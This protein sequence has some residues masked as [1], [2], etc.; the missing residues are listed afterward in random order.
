VNL[1]QIGRA[2]GLS[3]APVSC[4]AQPEGD[5]PP[6]RRVISIKRYGFVHQAIMN[7]IAAGNTGVATVLALRFRDAGAYAL[8]MLCV[9]VAAMSLL[10]LG[11]YW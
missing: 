3:P 7:V 5:A 1:T 4:A 8:A 9:P 10:M 11:R 2:L 6:G